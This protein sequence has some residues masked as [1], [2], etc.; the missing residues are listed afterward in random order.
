MAAYAHSF[1]LPTH[2]SLFSED[3]THLIVRVL[4]PRI[5][6]SSGWC[7]LPSGVFSVL[8]P[9]FGFYL[10]RVRHRLYRLFSLGSRCMI[11]WKDLSEG[12]RI[13]YLVV[14]LFFPYLLSGLASLVSL[15]SSHAPET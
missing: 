1:S 2:H 11:S 6:G 13:M 3:D 7:Q 4:V 10:S 8:Y 15:V 9:A 14:S 12:I 5:L